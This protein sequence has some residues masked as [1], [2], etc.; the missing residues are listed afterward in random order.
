MN[1]M[2]TK[3][4]NTELADELPISLIAGWVPK[5]VATNVTTALDAGIE[6]H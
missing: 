2:Q 1:R 4:V 6:A 3:N 5:H